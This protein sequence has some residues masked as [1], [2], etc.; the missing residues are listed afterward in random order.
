MQSQKLSISLSPTLTRFIEHYKTAK[1]YKS[2]SEVISIAL[3]LL[4]EK[5]LFEAYH[6]ASTEVDEDWDVTVADGL[7]DETW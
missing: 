5:E 2:R 1:G 6:Q 7:S 3:T 4:Q